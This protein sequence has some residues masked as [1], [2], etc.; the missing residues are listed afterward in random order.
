MTFYIPNISKLKS[1][2][3]ISRFIEIH[4]PDIGNTSKK[5]DQIKKDL[6]IFFP[7]FDLHP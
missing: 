4:D 3:S 6:L 1:I 7:D 2:I 5:Y